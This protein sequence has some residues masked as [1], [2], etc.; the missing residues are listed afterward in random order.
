MARTLVMDVEHAPGIFELTGVTL[1]ETAGATTTLGFTD[2]LNLLRGDKATNYQFSWNSSGFAS[3]IPGTY[4]VSVIFEEMGPGEFAGGLFS[5]STA[6][7]GPGAYAVGVPIAAGSIP[8]GVYRVTAILT[9]DAGVNPT[10][11]VA[12]TEIPMVR[13]FSSNIP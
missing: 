8:D 6:N 10:P 13:V 11:I 1:S 4:R 5:A 9:F 7:T 12:M 2:N 3:A